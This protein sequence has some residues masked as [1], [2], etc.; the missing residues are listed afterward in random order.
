VSL[1]S[2]VRNVLAHSFAFLA[3]NAQLCDNPVTP[4][5]NLAALTAASRSG[6]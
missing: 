5:T 2:A 6:V 4:Q 1:F 3:Q